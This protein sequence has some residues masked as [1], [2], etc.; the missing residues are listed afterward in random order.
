[1][2][3]ISEYLDEAKEKHSIKSDAELARLLGGSRQSVSS[4]RAGTNKPDDYACIRLAELLGINPLEI[5]A[6]ANA[7]READPERAKWWLDFSK[8]HGIKNLSVSLIGMNLH[9]QVNNLDFL[10][11]VTNLYIM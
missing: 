4:W 8:R 10:E 2:K 6:A 9:L 1:M 5:I 11:A 7:E 3:T